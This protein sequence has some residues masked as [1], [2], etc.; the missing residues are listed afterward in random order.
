MSG[1][2]PQQREAIRYLDGPLLVLAGAGSGKT[3]V[4]TQKIAY[5]VE[6]CGVPAAQRGRHHLHQ[7]GGEG[8]AGARRQ[9]AVDG[10][11]PKSCNISTFHSLGVRILREEAQGAGL[12][13]ALLDF[14]SRPIAPASSVTLAGTVDKAR[15]R[16]LQSYISQ[17]EECPGR[18]R[19]RR[20]IWPPTNIEVARGARL[21]RTTRRR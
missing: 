12:Q 6:D 8:D 18:R 7:Q 11:P 9:A 2:N 1:L 14:R 16:R 3:R 5:L 21:R 19:K 15:L 13:A 4:I 17:L 20:R 10:R